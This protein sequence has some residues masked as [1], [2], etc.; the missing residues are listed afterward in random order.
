VPLS[1]KAQVPTPGNVPV[2]VALS[3]TLESESWAVAVPVSVTGPLH[4]TEKSPDADVVVCVVMVH[5]K[6]PQP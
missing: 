1:E 4:E 3:W 6:L 5:W 2:P